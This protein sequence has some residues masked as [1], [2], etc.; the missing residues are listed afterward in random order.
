MVWGGGGGDKLPNRPSYLHIL[1]K[2]FSTKLL[3]LTK[4]GTNIDHLFVCLGSGE[5]WVVSV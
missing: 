2:I 3:D 1:A 4:R 5:C